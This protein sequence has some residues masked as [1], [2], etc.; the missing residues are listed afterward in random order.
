MKYVFHAFEYPRGQKCVSK[1]AQAW[2]KQEK[3]HRRVGIALRLSLQTCAGMAGTTNGA[4]S[5]RALSGAGSPGRQSTGKSLPDDAKLLA[6]TLAKRTI[7]IMQG[8]GCFLMAGV[9]NAAENT[10]F[11]NAI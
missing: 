5:N 4:Y 8:Q 6:L 2:L 10:L 9:G 1:P 11:G 3:V 7:A